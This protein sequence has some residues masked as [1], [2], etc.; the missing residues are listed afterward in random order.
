MDEIL[1]VFVEVKIYIIAWHCTQV[2]MLY[3]LFS[4]F[5]NN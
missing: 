5:S 2:F 3:D 1:D 4:L